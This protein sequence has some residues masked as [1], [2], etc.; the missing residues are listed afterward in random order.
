MKRLKI[1]KRTTHD[2]TS[3]HHRGQISVPI[4]RLHPPE[5]SSAPGLHL[6]APQLITEASAAPARWLVLPGH[7]WSLLIDR[8]VSWSP[9]GSGKSQ[10]QVSSRHGR[11]ACQG[12]AGM[13]MCLFRFVDRDGRRHCACNRNAWA[14]REGP[15]GCTAV[16]VSERC[17]CRYLPY[18]TV[19]YCKVLLPKARNGRAEGYSRRFALI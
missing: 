14:G 19:L 2:I 4:L 10:S 18:R 9:Q 12:L 13:W 11:C 8:K 15:R 3:L 17:R 7:A 5:V 1:F 6:S 16:V